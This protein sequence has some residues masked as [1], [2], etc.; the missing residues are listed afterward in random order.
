MKHQPYPTSVCLQCFYGLPKAHK[1]N[2]PNCPIIVSACSATY[3]LTKFMA[4]IIRP[5]VRNARHGS[6]N[7][8][9]F[10]LRIKGMTPK[11]EKTH[12]F[13]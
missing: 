5:F 3:D 2:V 1:D 13:V 4:Y 12:H 7:C 11:P 8:F 10:V 6:Q 9:E